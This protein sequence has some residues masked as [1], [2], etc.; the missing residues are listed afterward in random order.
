MKKLL[1]GLGVMALC[2]TGCGDN[3]EDVT[4]CDVNNQDADCEQSQSGT[5]SSTDNQDS[6]GYKAI[7]N[8]MFER[9]YHF[10]RADAISA[11][12]LEQLRQA[13]NEACEPFY[14]NFPE[15]KPELHNYY[16]CIYVDNTEEYWEGEK[17][18]EEA[19]YETYGDETP[20]A[21]A[22]VDKLFQA[23]VTPVDTA[24]LCLAKYEDIFE[25]YSKTHESPYDAVDDL[26]AEWG[27]DIDDL[28]D[29]GE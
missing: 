6:T 19:C 27:L 7:C 18:K 13:H 5:Q 25:S 20:E 12:K 1:L 11:D 26:L 23:C 16:K 28:Y 29:G 14:S 8:A 4:E 9:D 24:E 10:E 21:E 3:N 15:C 2:L 17:D 22:C